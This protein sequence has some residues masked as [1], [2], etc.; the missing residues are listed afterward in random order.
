MGTVLIDPAAIAA[1]RDAEG[2]RRR[3]RRFIRPFRVITHGRKLRYTMIDPAL[4]RRHRNAARVAAAT[5]NPVVLLLRVVLPFLALTGLGFACGELLMMWF[6][7]DL[8]GR[9]IVVGFITGLMAM[10]AI[11][12]LVAQFSQGRALRRHTKTVVGDHARAMV[13]IEKACRF[14]RKADKGL[15][16]VEMLWDAQFDE[17]LAVRTARSLAT[18]PA[19][20]YARVLSHLQRGPGVDLGPGDFTMLGQLVT[21]K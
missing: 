7:N 15:P 18:L 20:E 2:M 10:V 1:M 19:D 21:P 6:D 9:T 12:L 8:I 16:A 13:A 5:F 11:A 3:R 17:G 14:A 4:N